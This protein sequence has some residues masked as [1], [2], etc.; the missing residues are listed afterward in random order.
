MEYSHR[1]LRPQWPL[2]ATSAALLAWGCGSTT[3]PTPQV[4]TVTLDGA[5]A[6]PDAGQPAPDMPP[7]TPPG[8]PTMDKAAPTV[9]QTATFALG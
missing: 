8:A 1:Y 5:A 4:N 9:T 3:Q 7:G 2:V 6:G